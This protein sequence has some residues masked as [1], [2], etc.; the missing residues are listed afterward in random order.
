[1]SASPGWF[2]RRLASLLVHG[3]DAPYVLGDLEEGMRRDLARGMSTR[4][5]RIRYLVNVLASAVSLA[6]ARIPARRPLRATPSWID[7]KLGWRM[8][9]KN[10]VLTLVAITSL[11]IGIPVGMAP[12][13]VMEAF[14]APPPVEHGDRLVGLRYRG[15]R[16]DLAA[17]SYEL[18]VWRSGLGSFETL[19]AIRRL[20]Y[21]LAPEGG[22]GAPV[23]AAEVTASAFAALGTRPFLGRPLQPEDE[24]PAAPPVAVLG[25]DVWRS[26][27]D[28]APGVVGS[29][30][31][32]SGTPHTVVGV[33]PEGFRFPVHEGLW[34]PLRD[35][36][37][38]E[39]GRGCRS[40]SLDG[41]PRVFRRQRHRLRSR[42]SSAAW[43]T[44]TP[45]STGPTPTTGC[46]SRSS[47]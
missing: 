10:P 11:A 42:P 37:A 9:R 18:D 30:V 33:M 39:P 45:G 32:V 25:Y 23:A 12:V 1:M 41:S 4:R 8:L 27:F 31:R 29:T 38:S 28:A 44:A 26:R 36:L 22:A 43:P 2:L 47:P 6:R 20:E 34:I 5:A 7:V 16:G 15:G 40:R 21:N 24:R 13:H 3:P 35:D 17:T 14:D 19:G 46:G